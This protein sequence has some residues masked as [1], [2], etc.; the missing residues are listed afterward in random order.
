MVETKHVMVVEDDLDLCEAIS[1]V[2]E[3]DGFDVTSSDD[4]EDALEK[5]RA[6]GLRLVFLDLGL[7]RMSGREFMASC[8]REPLLRATP[9]VLLSGEQGL[10]VVAQ[11]LGAAA[12]LQKP[13]NTKELLEIAHR[14]CPCVEV[15]NREKTERLDPRS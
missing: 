4:G 5:L 15:S 8:K 1:S 13:F 12:H 6:G 10:P 2:L 7:K 3:D 9:V 11:Q 14:L